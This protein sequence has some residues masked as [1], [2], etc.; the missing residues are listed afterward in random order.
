LENKKLINKKETIIT[1][2]EKLSDNSMNL[3][4]SHINFFEPSEIQIG[5]K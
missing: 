5:N 4:K 1:K 2:F 3:N